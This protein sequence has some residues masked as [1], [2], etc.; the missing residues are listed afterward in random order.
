MDLKAIVSALRT[1]LISGEKTCCTTEWGNYGKKIHNDPFSR[2]YWIRKGEGRIEYENG[3]IKLEPG[4]LIAVP[5][6]IPALYSCE[7]G[8]ELYWVHFRAELFGS[9]DIFKLMNWDYT[10]EINEK[11]RMTSFFA[12]LV[13]IVKSEKLEDC[14]TA[15][16]ML[17]QLLCRFAL[18]TKNI[19]HLDDVQ[20][21][22]PAIV[23]IEQNLHR[24]IT[25]RDLTKIVPLESAYFCSLFSKTIGE[26]PMNFINRK[27]IEKSQFLMDDRDLSLKQ[28]AS[29]VGFDDV[30]YFSRVFKNMVGIAPHYY[31][32]Q[33]KV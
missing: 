16:T 6:F 31:R 4:K 30:Y 29:K 17:R 18:K 25:L 7:N 19:M 33:E 11:G 24:R 32:K 2:L 9:Q 22:L 26:T 8:M 28:I 27:K 15:D 23:F 20:R 14:L 3:N 1:E 13:R 21:F 10:V 5:P 12:K